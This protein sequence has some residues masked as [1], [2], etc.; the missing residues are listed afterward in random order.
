LIQTT[1]YNASVRNKVFSF[2]GATALKGPRPSCLV[3]RSHTIRHTHKHTHLVGL[4]S[5]SDQF[6]AEAA[7]Y[8][9]RNKQKRRT[10]MPSAEF[11]PATPGF[12]KLQTYVLARTANGIGTL[13]LTNRFRSTDLALNYQLIHCNNAFPGTMLSGKKLLRHL[14]R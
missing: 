12:Q 11:E 1:N 14:V 8:T 3:Y 9:A 6:V 13:T 10:S 2:Y 7:N 4:V 5:A